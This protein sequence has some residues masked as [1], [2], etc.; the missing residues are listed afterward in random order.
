MSNKTSIEGLSALLH[1]LML[2]P[3]HRW[4]TVKELQQQLA[5]MNISRTTRSIKRYL[6]EVIIEVFNVECD[7]TSMPHVYRKTSEQLLKFNKREMLYWQLTKKYLQPIIPEA[8]HYSLGDTLKRTNPLTY[9]E[10]SYSKELQWL[11]KVHIRLPTIQDWSDEQWQILD[12]VHNALLNCRMLKISSPFLQQGYMF[13]EPLGLSVQSDVILLLFRLSDQHPIRT[14]ALSLI[15]KAYI[16]TFS[17]RYPS[18]FNTE[19]FMRN[20]EELEYPELRKINNDTSTP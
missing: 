6:D 7:S 8:L 14:I 12:A 2:I 3:Q 4:I 1:T 11:H 10:L 13:I 19:Q 18:D 20:H 15:D 16:S 5:L 9:N 17:F